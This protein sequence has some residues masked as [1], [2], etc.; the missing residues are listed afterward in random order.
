MHCVA[1]NAPMCAPSCKTDRSFYAPQTRILEYITK[2]QS[3]IFDVLFQGCEYSIWAT[4]RWK[5]HRTDTIDIP[6]SS[7][8]S[9]LFVQRKDAP[10]TKSLRVCQSERAFGTWFL[11]GLCSPNEDFGRQNQPFRMRFPG[12]AFQGSEYSIWATLAF[13]TCFLKSSFSKGLTRL[14]LRPCEKDLGECAP[15]C[16]FGLAYSIWATF[17]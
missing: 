10:Q 5:I 6:K 9:I 11:K 2:G 15:R 8:G 13:G 4:S 3:C 7:F 17:P 16:L 1:P 12:S 14:V